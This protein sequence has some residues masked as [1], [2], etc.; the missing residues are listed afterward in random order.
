MTPGRC[1][2]AVRAAVFAATCVLL[3]T[4]GHILMSGAVLPWWA[5]S[6]AFAATAATAWALADRQRGVL[7][8]TSTAVAAQAALHTGFSMAQAAVHP[9]VS[10]SA[11][12]ARQGARLLLGGASASGA[13]TRSESVRIMTEGG[14]GHHLHLPSGTSG[15]ALT[16]S[17]TLSTGHDMGSMSP[18]GMLAAHLLAALLC[19]LWL[20]YG[21]QAAFRLLRT[22]AGWLAA[23]LRLLFRLPAPPHRPRV[24][25]RRDRR[26]RLLRQLLLT[27]AITS[28]GPPSGTAVI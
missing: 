8:V 4:L 21:E 11:S 6:A 2:R 16:D 28:R 1:C 26:A 15:L 7:V 3:A 13:P 27:H 24:R 18:A 17:T 20:A 22:F 25:V 9:S 23:P 10:D 19:G 14:Q 12:F 5:V